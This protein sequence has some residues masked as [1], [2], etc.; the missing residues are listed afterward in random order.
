MNQQTNVSEPAPGQVNAAGSPLYGLGAANPL[1]L[2]MAVVQL[3]IGLIVLFSKMNGLQQLCGIIVMGILAIAFIAAFVR[4]ASFQMAPRPS[5]EPSARIASE[6]RPPHVVTPQTASE[7]EL[8]E[9]AALSLIAD[10]EELPDRVRR[11][12]FGIV[13]DFDEERFIYTLVKLKTAVKSLIAARTSSSRSPEAEASH[14]QSLQLSSPA[15]AS[16]AVETAFPEAEAPA[17][18]GRLPEEPEAIHAV[19]VPHEEAGTPA[20]NLAL[21]G[22]QLAGEVSAP[23]AYD[24]EQPI[25]E[26]L[27]EPSALQA[28]PTAPPAEAPDD[29]FHSGA[30]VHLEAGEGSREEGE[31]AGAGSAEAVNVSA[32]GASTEQLEPAAPEPPPP[33]SGAEAI[34]EARRALRKGDVEAAIGL[35]R[36][37]GSADAASAEARELLGIALYRSGDEAGALEALN[38]AV[39]L[40]PQRASAHYNLAVVLNNAGNVDAARLHA[41]LA[42]DLKPD[43]AAALQ[44]RDRLAETGAGGSAPVT[45]ASKGAA[46]DP[47]G[48]G[49]HP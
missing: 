11:L 36:N 37:V 13:M 4:I 30:A 42:L 31:P 6:R 25:E 45:A 46:L 24:G 16:A 2:H 5:R 23:P 27:P 3:L 47:R 43:Y 38:T 33:I 21:E 19:L 17:R 26:P 15:R 49:A 8:N 9:E 10:L 48:S 22:S 20:S 14:S 32:A 18:E 41:D 39:S 7:P 40:D 29:T 44:L 12:P 35:L 1:S 28:I 34:A